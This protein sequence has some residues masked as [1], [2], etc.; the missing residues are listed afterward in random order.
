M[1]TSVGG[2]RGVKVRGGVGK[3]CFVKKKQPWP[4]ISKLSGNVT[5]KKAGGQKALFKEKVKGTPKVWTSN[6]NTAV[7]SH[8]WT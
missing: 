5:Q 8:D 3:A 6:K 4:L 1:L 7:S 2:G